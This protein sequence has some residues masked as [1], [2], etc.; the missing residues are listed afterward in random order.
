[1]KF[2]WEKPKIRKQKMRKKV[3]YVKNKKK[4]N[5]LR[6]CDSGLL[7]QIHFNDEDIW[8]SLWCW[9][10]LSHIFIW[11]KTKICFTNSRLEPMFVYVTKLIFLFDFPLKLNISIIWLVMHQNLEFR[12]D[13]LLRFELILVK[14]LSLGRLSLGLRLTRHSTEFK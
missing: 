7:L 1:M 13:F 6:V 12:F 10:Q 11:H 14:A 5:S 3:F 9:F 2:L 8:G 4:E